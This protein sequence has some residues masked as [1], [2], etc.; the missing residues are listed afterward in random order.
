MGGVN[1][2]GL[3]DSKLF[4]RSSIP[5]N[6]PLKL[7]K[8]GGGRIGSLGALG[9]FTI[10][11]ALKRTYLKRIFSSSSQ[12]L[13]HADPYCIAANHCSCRARS[14]DSRFGLACLWG[15]RC[16]CRRRSRPGGLLGP[17]GPESDRQPNQRSPHLSSRILL[18]S[19]YVLGGLFGPEGP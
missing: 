17:S 19:F 12:R 18:Y 6:T 11:C 4:Q 10:G 13:L 8:T 5:F 9:A 7:V 1:P 14:R 15:V 2:L 16:A 3:F